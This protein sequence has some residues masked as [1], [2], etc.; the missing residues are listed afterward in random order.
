MDLTR[1]GVVHTP[2]LKV[3]PESADHLVV[4]TAPSKTFNLAGMQLS[5][6]VIPNNEWQK[7]CLG[8]IDDA[9]SEVGIRDRYLTVEKLRLLVPLSFGIFPEGFSPEESVNHPYILKPEQLNGLDYIPPVS[10]THLRNVAA[11]SAV[12]ASS[13]P[14]AAPAISIRGAPNFPKMKI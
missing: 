2:L 8:V 1:K 13:V 6:I 5:N 7:K 11:N 12:L 3:A 4:C 9:F 10:Y 14:R